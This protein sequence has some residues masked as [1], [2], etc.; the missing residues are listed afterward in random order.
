MEELRQRAVVAEEGRMAMVKERWA[1]L[2]VE[3][4]ADSQVR[5]ESAVEA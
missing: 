4:N 2:D 1:K 3:F 5:A